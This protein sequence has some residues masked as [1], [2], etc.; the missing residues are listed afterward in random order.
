MQGSRSFDYNFS[1]YIRRKARSE[2]KQHKGETDPAKIEKLLVKA[3][4]GLGVV[5]RQGLIQLAYRGTHE[6][7]VMETKQLLARQNRIAEQRK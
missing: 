6:P 3:K 7:S 4:E 5:E 1:H 2:F